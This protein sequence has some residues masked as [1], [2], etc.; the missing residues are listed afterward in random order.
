MTNVALE[1]KANGQGKWDQAVGRMHSSGWEPR[2]YGLWDSEEPGEVKEQGFGK[3]TSSQDPN[4]L[5]LHQI[6]TLLPPEFLGRRSVFSNLW[7]S[8]F[9]KLDVLPHPPIQYMLV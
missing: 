3:I 1:R 9:W 8:L 2:D 6:A 4:Y 7:G 5:N